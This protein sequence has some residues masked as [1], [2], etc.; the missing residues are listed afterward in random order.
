MSPAAVANTVEV[1]IANCFRIV[2][3]AYRTQTDDHLCRKQIGGRANTKKAPLSFKVWL[4][5]RP[6]FS[7]SQNVRLMLLGSIA[8][9]LQAA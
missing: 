7:F 2:G 3:G 4:L 8:N 5:I 9:R 1:E 6:T